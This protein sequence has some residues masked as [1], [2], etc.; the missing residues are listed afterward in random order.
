MELRVLWDQQ[1][2]KEDSFLAL[3]FGIFEDPISAMK[4][5]LV[6]QVPGE[7]LYERVD[8]SATGERKQQLFLDANNHILVKPFELPP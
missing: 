7:N 6:R 5:V 4:W 2:G 1:V 8:C 3:P